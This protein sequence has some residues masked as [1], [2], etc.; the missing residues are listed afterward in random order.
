MVKRKGPGIKIGFCDRYDVGADW[1]RSSCSLDVPPPHGQLLEKP[2]ML[3]G[4]LFQSE[5][6]LH[7]EEGKGRRGVQERCHE[8]ARSSVIR[9]A[10]IAGLYRT[11]TVAGGALASGVG[12]G[13]LGALG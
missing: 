4:S 6:T 9:L 13:R 2:P 10:L 11:L 3:R 7:R 8:R 1:R 12:G 5:S